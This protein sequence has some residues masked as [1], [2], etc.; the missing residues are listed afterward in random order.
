[1]SLSGSPDAKSATRAML[2]PVPEDDK[3]YMFFL[4][5]PGNLDNQRLMSDMEHLN[6]Q[7]RLI[8]H[9]PSFTISKVQNIA[10]WRY[11]CYCNC[12][13][14]WAYSAGS[15]NERV[16]DC[17]RVSRVLIAG[18]TCGFMLQPILRFAYKYV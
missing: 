9:R 15:L 16:A 11:V 18:G 13:R 2:R 14:N 10:E 5:G 6:E 17:F 7:M 3:T 4:A 8:S 12:S 1:M